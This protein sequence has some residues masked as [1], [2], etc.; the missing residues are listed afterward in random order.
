MCTAFSRV[1]WYRGDF[2]RHLYIYTEAALRRYME[3]NGFE[4]ILCRYGREI[5]ERDPH[6]WLFYLKHVLFRKK[7]RFQIAD[8]KMSR[9][10]FFDENGLSPKV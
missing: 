5:F 1:Q 10:Q 8:M 4:V 9:K 3:V 7:E 6:D 2:P